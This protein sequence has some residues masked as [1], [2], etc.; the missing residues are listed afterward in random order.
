LEE[1]T[2][3]SPCWMQDGS[4]LLTK[5]P[6]RLYEFTKIS[7]L[8]RIYGVDSELLKPDEIKKMY[9]LINTT[10]LAGGVFNSTSG[11]VSPSN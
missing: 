10:D 9:P 6:D 2:G 7:N 11:H 3:I 8:S 4:L 1:E 5:H